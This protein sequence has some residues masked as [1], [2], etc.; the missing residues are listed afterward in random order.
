MKKESY[1]KGDEGIGVMKACEKDMTVVAK[2][3]KRRSGGKGR[4]KSGGKGRHESG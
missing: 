1:G 2:M 4:R 3:E